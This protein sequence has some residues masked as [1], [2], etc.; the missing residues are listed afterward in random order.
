MWVNKCKNGSDG[1]LINWS[2]ESTSHT[3][4]PFHFGGCPLSRWVVKRREWTRLDSAGRVRIELGVFPLSACEVRRGE[5]TQTCVYA[6]SLLISVSN[7]DQSREHGRS[8]IPVKNR[9]RILYSGR[10]YSHLTCILYLFFYITE[11]WYFV[12]FGSKI[13][14]EEKFPVFKVYNGSGLSGKIDV[15]DLFIRSTW[16][17][18]FLW[19]R[20]EDNFL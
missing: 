18:S 10:P 17:S 11:Q 1:E 12:S 2:V 14:T 20:L 7:H 3:F 15:W 13:F 19:R 4:V 6:E 16:S 5:W 8:V 9:E